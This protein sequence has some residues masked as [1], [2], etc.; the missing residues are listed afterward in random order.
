[1]PSLGSKD[2]YGDLLVKV[3]V[4]L[5]QDLSEKEKDLFKELAHLR[6]K[7]G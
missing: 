4:K 2:A 3:Q 1:M 7:V 6:D 5:P